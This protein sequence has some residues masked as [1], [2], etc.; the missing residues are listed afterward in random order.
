[1]PECNKPYLATVRAFPREYDLVERLEARRQIDLYANR[2]TTCYAKSVGAQC[3]DTLYLHKD[4]TFTS[5]E[6]LFFGLSMALFGFGIVLPGLHCFGQSFTGVKT[7][8]K[9]KTQHEREI[10]RKKKEMDELLRVKNAA[11]N[12]T[13]MQRSITDKLGVLMSRG[14]DEH[15]W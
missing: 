13:V 14:E 5:T 2:T 3:S 7:Y 4:K 8:Y 15:Q 12:D 9:V 1:M 10:K 11:P 6:W